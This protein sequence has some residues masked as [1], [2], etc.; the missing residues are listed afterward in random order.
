M[1][2]STDAAPE[3]AQSQAAPRPVP[4]PFTLDALRVATVAA[5][6]GLLAAFA[7]IWRAIGLNV[8]VLT[9]VGV[10]A[11]LALAAVERVRPAWRSLWLVV[12][13]LFF[14]AS[15]AW[16]ANPFIQFLNVAAVIGLTVLLAKVFTRPDLFTQGVGGYLVMALGGLVEGSL[17]QPGE[18]MFAAS[19][20]SRSTTRSPWLWSLARGLLLATPIV[21]LV[22]ERGAFTAV[23][24]AAVAPVLACYAVQIPFYLAGMIGVQVLAALC[25]YR[26]LAFISTSNFLLNIALNLLLVRWIG[27]PGIALATSLVYVVSSTMIAFLVWPHLSARQDGDAAALVVAWR[28]AARASRSCCIASASLKMSGVIILYLLYAPVAPRGQSSVRGCG[29]PAWCACCEQ[30][31]LRNIEKPLSQTQGPRCQSRVAWLS[32][33]RKQPRGRLCPAVWFLATAATTSRH[34]AS[35]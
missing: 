34:V 5:G 24:T 23:D 16:R 22:F 35:P 11:L 12:P 20:Q 13:L 32:R 17:L 21:R 7:L 30:R 1:T 15:V 31:R 8:A 9:A 27:L 10:V 2:L 14:G 25:H 33:C 4:P 19:R 29:R 18:A 6:L 26:A 3:A 28:A